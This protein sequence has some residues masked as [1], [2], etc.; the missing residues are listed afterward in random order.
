MVVHSS[1]HISHFA[2]GLR[3]SAP[4]PHQFPAVLSTVVSLLIRESGI[5]R[6]LGGPEGDSAREWTERLLA[7]YVQ[8]G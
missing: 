7:F 4:T 2:F 5:E 1:F 3:S 6:L 8:F